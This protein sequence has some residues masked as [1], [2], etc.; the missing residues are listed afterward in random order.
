[1]SHKM[2]YI[3]EE[4]HRL[5]NQIFSR[6]LQLPQFPLGNINQDGEMEERV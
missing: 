1:M 2:G 3:K 6:L 4:L 5:S